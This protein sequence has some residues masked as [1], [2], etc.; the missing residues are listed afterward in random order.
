[1]ASFQTIEEFM[2][3]PFG[4]KSEKS[5]ELEAMYKNLKNHHK[6]QIS[7]YTQIKDDHLLHLSVG[8]DSNPKE[9]YDVV[10]LFFTD[11]EELKKKRDFRDYYIKFF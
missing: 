9:N 10:L 4:E 7:G 1:M 5:N 11:D 6:I 2:Q 8:S 3:T